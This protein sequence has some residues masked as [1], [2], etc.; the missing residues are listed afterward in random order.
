MDR[1]VENG[2][3]S[4]GVFMNSHTLSEAKKLISLDYTKKMDGSVP[5]V[6]EMEDTVLQ[7][8]VGIDAIF[9]VSKLHKY[10]NI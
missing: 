7:D 1:G 9:P 2:D 8:G 4:V 5:N 6:S 3:V 10:S